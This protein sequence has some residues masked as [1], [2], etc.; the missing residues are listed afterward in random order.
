[1]RK[2]KDASE[3]LKFVFSVNGGKGVI[4]KQV[5]DG[6]DLYQCEDDEDQFQVDLVAANDEEH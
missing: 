4:C 5:N 6:L 1:V 3:P 2:E